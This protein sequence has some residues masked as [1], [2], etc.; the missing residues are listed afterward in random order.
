CHV[1]GAHRR[2]GPS[3][4]KG[5]GSYRDVQCEACHGPSRAHAER[6]DDASLRP[7]RSPD[8][9]TCRTCHDGEQDG[10]RFDLATY[11]P[12]VVHTQAGP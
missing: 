4:P 1:T 9:A 12:Q 7:V 8:E 10:G 5:T 3:A 2:G 6:P 11:L